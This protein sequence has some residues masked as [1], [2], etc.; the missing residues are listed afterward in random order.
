MAKISAKKRHTIRKSMI[1]KIFT[2]LEEQIGNGTDAFRSSQVE[3]VETD[4]E[5]IVYLIDKK[6]ALMA[7]EGWVFPTLRGAIAHPFSQRTLT[8]DSGAI[9]FMV[10]GADVMR[11]GVVS[12]SDDVRKGCPVLIVEERYRKPLAVAIALYDAEEMRALDKGKVAKNIHFVGDDIWNLD[13]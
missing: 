10:K 9:S 5:I 6:S 1:G 13:I 11:P 12:I 4:S 7:Y 2:N 3:M 8:V